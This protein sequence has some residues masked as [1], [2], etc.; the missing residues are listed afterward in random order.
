[1]HTQVKEDAAPLTQW[2]AKKDD[3]LLS[4]IAKCEN[5]W[6]QAFD[7]FFNRHKKYLYGI[8]YNLVNRYKFGFFDEDD[9]FQTTMLK[10]LKGA[11]TFNSD[12]VV[13][14]EELEQKADAW[15]GGIAENAVFD[16]FRRKPKC[17]P[18]DPQILD[19]DEDEI[20]IPA[21]EAIPCEE[22]E[23]I[24]LIRKAVDSLPPNQQAAIWV[25]SLFYERRKHQRTPSEDL[26]EIV[27]SLGMSKAAFRKSKASSQQ[28]ARHY[29]NLNSTCSLYSC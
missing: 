19:T 1:L 26:N 15:L 14:A 22:T 23:E 21:E 3:E 8:C 11:A 10:A 5:E 4:C 6:R 27:G 9:L 16:L 28:A 20:D 18:F 24:K 17:I 12:G 29:Q 13:D 2:D 25:T 7:V